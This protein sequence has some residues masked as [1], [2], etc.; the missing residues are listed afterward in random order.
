MKF[1]RGLECPWHKYFVDLRSGA[2]LYRSLE[3]GRWAVKEGGKEKQ[4]THDVVLRPV[5]GTFA[6]SLLGRET[7][8]EV[9]VRLLSEGT[10]ESD[11]Y[12]DTRH[13]QALS[14]FPPPEAS[15]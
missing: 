7:Q 14:A 3:P 2:G 12:A 15:T 8:Y 5:Q 6:S 13:R 4:R 1:P 11:H 10:V 9:W